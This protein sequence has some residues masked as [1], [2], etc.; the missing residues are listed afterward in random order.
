[1]HTYI[2]S[3]IFHRLKILYVIVYTKVGIRTIM[4]SKSEKKATAELVK[5]YKKNKAAADKL[6]KE[7]DK[8]EKEAKQAKKDADKAKERTA[9]VKKLYEEY[10]KKHA[11]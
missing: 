4:S 3:T 2:N 1:M 8:A 9:R 6:E 5:R 11:K 10:K 7:R